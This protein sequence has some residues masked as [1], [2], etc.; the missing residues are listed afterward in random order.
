[1][2]SIIID[3]DAGDDIDDVL[4]I[5]FAALRPELELLAVTTVVHDVARRAAL[6]RQVLE[7]AD[8]GHV[9]IAAG[10]AMPL[11]PLHGEERQRWIRGDGRWNHCPEAGL[12]TDEH[13]VDLMAR[14]IESRPG[15][16]T[17]VG[18]GPLT[19]IALLIAQRPDLVP[20]LKAIALMGG[21]LAQ[22]RA[23]YN[24]VC[25]DIA[26]STVFSCDAPIFLG[27][28]SVT[29]QVELSPQDMA[30]LANH[31]SPLTTLLAQ[32]ESRWRP[33]Q[34]WK[35]GPVMYDLAPILWRF[36]PDLFT[37]KAM[38]VTV[39]TTGAHT[40][41]WTIPTQGPPHV[42]VTQT[43]NAGEAK[44]MLMQTLMA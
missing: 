28:W 35:T 6:V 44:A 13:A 39:E 19:N 14:V 4:A 43:M 32:C 29:K 24:I 3:T 12:N 27:T 8:R 23:E 2:E 31:G 38:A 26:A 7:A 20:K 42:H 21:E 25:D 17:L 18:I 16:V 15:D 33:L 22:M 41:G 9:P 40:R 5:A 11:R 30:T 37:T 36:R 10:A 34:K 1:M